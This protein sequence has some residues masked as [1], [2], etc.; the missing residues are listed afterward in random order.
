MNFIRPL[1]ILLVSRR[2]T[3]H[4]V[5]DGTVL[6]GVSYSGIVMRRR[7]N[8]TIEYRQPTDEERDEAIAMW[9]TK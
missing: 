7:I 3:S 6:D 8:R 1:L 2:W 9:A 4:L 5:P